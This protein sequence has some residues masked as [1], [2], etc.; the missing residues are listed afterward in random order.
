VECSLF[1]LILQ[2]LIVVNDERELFKWAPLLDERY[3]EKMT[4][5]RIFLL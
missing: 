3:R 4:L 5:G 1:A 2:L